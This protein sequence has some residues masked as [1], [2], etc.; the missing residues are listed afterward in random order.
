MLT[1]LLKLILKLYL[2]KL[3]FSYKFYIVFVIEYFCVNIKKCLRIS[4]AM[5][6]STVKIQY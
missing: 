6:I 1:C 3:L 5:K 2:P 4:Y